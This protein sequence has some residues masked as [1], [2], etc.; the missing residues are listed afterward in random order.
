MTIRLHVV[1][2]DGVEH[3]LDVAPQGSL[4]EVLRDVDYGV[5]ALCGG[6]C[7]CATC[8]IYVAP[9]WRDK[10]PAQHGDERDLISDLEFRHDESR[11][12]CQI[13][14]CETLDNMHLRLAPEE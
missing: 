14:L 11:L 5:L 6:M 9:D 4:M 2:R 8:H 12:S 1:D 3:A 10:I 13:T 7:A